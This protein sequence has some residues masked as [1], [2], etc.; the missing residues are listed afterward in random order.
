MPEQSSKREDKEV[1]SATQTD[2]DDINNNS[3]KQR[4][5]DDYEL[6]PQRVEELKKDPKVVV[7]CELQEELD[8]EFEERGLHF[9]APGKA[10]GADKE[11]DENK[12]KGGDDK[13]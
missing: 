2:D 6:S 9:N 13:A 4:G 7:H 8:R 5:K 3:S 10:E 1:D 11:D 12:Q